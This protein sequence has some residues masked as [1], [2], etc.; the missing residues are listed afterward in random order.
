[1]CIEIDLIGLIGAEFKRNGCG[2]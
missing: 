2:S 1:M